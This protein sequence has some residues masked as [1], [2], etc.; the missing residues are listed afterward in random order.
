[1]LTDD[2]N[3]KFHDVHVAAAQ[4]IA[5][6]VAKHNVSRFIHLS[7]YNADPNSESKFYATKVFQFKVFTNIRAREKK[8]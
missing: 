2:R 4:R 8:R 5:E 6:A 3:F 1:M 7:S